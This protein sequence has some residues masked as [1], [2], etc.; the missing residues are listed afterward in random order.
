MPKRKWSAR[1][2]VCASNIRIYHK[3]KKN[4]RDSVA[5]IVEPC[6]DGNNSVFVPITS[7]HGARANISETIDW[8]TNG[9]D[10][11]DDFTLMLSDDEDNRPESPK[12]I[13]DFINDE[14]CSDATST[15]GAEIREK[16]L[17][18]YISDIEKC[19]VNERDESDDSEI[20]SVPK[21]I[22][23]SL[24]RRMLCS[25]CGQHGKLDI[26]KR[27]FDVDLISK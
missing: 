11:E 27:K 22:L 7:F 2:A 14:H 4:E 16:L 1:R 15:F 12:E 18:T 19:L 21:G 23:K 26:V 13:M 25:D 8:F 20:I 3:K 17:Q 5:T 24:F 9:T 10:I 6:G